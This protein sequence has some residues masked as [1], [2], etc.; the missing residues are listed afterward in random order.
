MSSANFIL[1]E[2]LSIKNG[3][4]IQIY[5]LKNVINHIG[6]AHNGHYYTT[7]INEN[8]KV[9]IDDNQLLKFTNFNNAYIL[10]YS[11]SD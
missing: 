1:N 9:N 10:F 3:D 2:T 6:N 8:E 7:I 11:Q 5:K 4:F